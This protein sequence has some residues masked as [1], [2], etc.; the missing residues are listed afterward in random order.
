MYLFK[1][2]GVYYIEYFDELENRV[3]RKSTRK[4]IKNDALKFLSDFKVKLSETP[5]LKFITLENL[6]DEYLA[7]LKIKFSKNHF[8]LSELSLRVFLEATGNIPINELRLHHLE[9]FVLKKY[10]QSKYS[11]HLHFRNLRAILNYA[12][13][14][15]Y[16]SENPLRKFKFP[17]MPRNIPEFIDETQLRHIISFIDNQNLKDMYLLYYHTGTRLNELIHLEWN[18]VDLQGRFITIRNTETFST[19]TKQERII[20]LNETAFQIFQR[21]I[22]KVI[23]INSYVFTKN[24]VRLNGN[25]VS[26]SFMKAC[27]LAGF[28]NIHLHSLRHSFCSNLIK[29]GNVSIRTV[30]ALAGHSNLATTQRYLGIKNESLFEAVK[31]LEG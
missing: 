12:V 3:R 24:C 19:K 26:K 31:F 30:M 7:L 11:A 10:Q 28:P 27:R 18:A 22:P 21:H 13:E 1:R 2:A 25:Y 6:R 14:R 9:N 4:T 29:N 17:Q 23:K 8:I 20:P 16:I 15:N 5:K